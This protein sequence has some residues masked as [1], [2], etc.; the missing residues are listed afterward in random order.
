MKYL[1]LLLLGVGSFCKAHELTPTYPKLSQSYVPGVLQTTVKLWNGRQ[2]VEYFS[3]EVTDGKWNPVEFITNEKI[4]R[5]EY[6]NRKNIDIFL[7]GSTEAVYICTRSMIQKGQKQKT[8][9]S[10]KVCSKIQ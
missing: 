3:V 2:D 9:I 10:S 6:L 7:P 8:V 4:L 1:L 5:L